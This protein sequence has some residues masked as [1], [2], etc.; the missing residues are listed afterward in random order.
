MTQWISVCTCGLVDQSQSEFDI[1]QLAICENCGK[2]VREGRQ[3][4]FTQWIFRSDLCD[5]DIPAPLK[6]QSDSAEIL[7]EGAH[8]S[9][10]DQF[11][12]LEI[13]STKFPVNRFKPIE[14][15]GEGATGTVYL[16]IDRHLNKK[17]AV[18]CLH[19]KQERDLV[20]FQ[21]E[22]KIY[23]KLNH[24]N[25]L[26]AFDF[27]VLQSQTPYMVLE[28]FENNTLESYLEKHGQ[29]RESLALG[30]ALQLCEALIHAHS[31]GILHK[32]VK[33]RNV[34]LTGSESFSSKLFDFGMSEEED[35]ESS[36]SM[37]GTPR[38]MPPEVIDNQPHDARSE[39]YSLGCLL[40]EMLTGRCPFEGDSIFEVLNQHSKA[41]PPLLR[42]IK[43]D[44]TAGEPFELVIDKCLK[45]DPDERFQSIND[46]SSALMNIDV[47]TS[48]INSSESQAQVAR[49]DNSLKQILGIS[50]LALVVLAIA[51]GITY[52]QFTD[53]RALKKNEIKVD[54]KSL[55]KKPPVVIDHDLNS[56]TRDT[57]F[58][59]AP[60]GMLLPNNIFG[61]LDEDMKTI[62]GK[63][64]KR[65]SFHSSDITGEGLKYVQDE[66]FEWLS[67]SRTF[68]KDE[69]LKYLKK[70]DKL[71]RLWLTDTGITTKG[72]EQIGNLKNLMLLHLVSCKRIDDSSIEF[73][74]EHFPNLRELYLSNTAVTEKGLKKLSRL[75]NLK[76]LTLTGLKVKGEGLSS[77]RKLKIS[78]LCLN[79]TDIGD[80]DLLSLLKMK[81]LRFISIT[82]CK[83]ISLKGKVA[84]QR[85][86]GKKVKIIQIKDYLL[87]FD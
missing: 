63:G 32:D 35:L 77:V 16:A 61:Y 59:R 36:S 84:F 10:Y 15:L 27:G 53:T 82:G 51:L 5:C 62:P 13:D 69:N 86:A 49:K 30:I 2:R 4:T 72:L 46:L 67:F 73:I 83:N 22:A 43:A 23:T 42:E 68:L 76:L 26:K 66:K 75:K 3:G 24:P 31:K 52:K 45:K 71:T 37:R 6:P 21:K 65:V 54:K 60:D 28:Y 11:E 18:K 38:Y 85:K 44:F 55:E 41:K 1:E 78:T 29:L 20:A 58:T 34:L 50:S 74:V 80:D 87:S 7:A 70:Q 48:E 79:K 25:I 39:V 47:T 33:A 19:L 81:N 17:V 9:E 64:F 40:F 12:E 8:S 56:K 57:S 14:T